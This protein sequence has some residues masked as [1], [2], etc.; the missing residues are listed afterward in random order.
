MK[1]MK[2]VAIILLLCPPLLTGCWN[3]EELSDLA[4]VI[5]MGIDREP[6]TDEYRVSFQVFNPSSLSTASGQSAGGPF[7]I[8]FYSVS[9]STLFGAFRL[10]TQKVPRRLF[11]SHT[12]ILVIGESLAKSGMK[13]L[14]DFYER[15][16]ELRL[17][18]QVLI[19]RGT[20]AESV[21]QMVMPLETIPAVGMKKRL[22]TTSRAWSHTV[23]SSVMDVVQGLRGEGEPAVSGIQILGNEKIGK[24]KANLEQVDMPASL[25]A[26]GIA[27]FK[28]GKLVS[29]LDGPQARGVLRAQNKI[30]STVMALDYDGR[31]DAISI[32]ILKSVTKI[33][34]DLKEGKPVFHLKIREEGQV[35]EVHC[36]IDLSKRDVLVALQ[37][38]WSEETK[39]EVTQAI[40]AVQKKKSDILGFGRKV[41]QSNPEEWKQLKE[42]WPGIFA[43]SQVEVEVESYIRRTG[44]RKKPYF[45]AVLVQ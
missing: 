20:N 18:T 15:S 34:V 42:Q 30:Q 29:W 17:N 16:H 5:G 36:P 14:L 4:I 19:S 26:K 10:A 33:K 37:K 35:N 1:R 9:N 23:N 44:M 8:A 12:Q 27:V 45:W 25:Q 38:Q 7:P 22:D 28:D 32:E 21:L 3:K 43:K 24:T 6:E 31:K 39:K 13:D 2:R 11:F 41:E 40:R